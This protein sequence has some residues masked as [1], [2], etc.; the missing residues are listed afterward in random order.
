MKTDL[1]LYAERELLL[2]VYAILFGI[3]AGAVYD[4]FRIGRTFLGCGLKPDKRYSERELPLIGRQK[5]SESKIGKGVS[6]VMLTL[7]DI[8]YMIVFAISITLFYYSVNDGI[9]RWYTLLGVGAGFYAYMKTLGVI[10][11]KTVGIIL[12]VIACIGRYIWYFGIKP[13]RLLKKIYLKTIGAVYLKILRRRSAFMI[14]KY[15]KVTL[16]K[17]FDEISV[18]VKTENA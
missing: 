5:Q 16:K 14:E 8:V 11:K 17:R 2:I 4:L 10:T 13:F 12:F 1:H 15:T 18:A 7:L 3:A 9:V 6:V